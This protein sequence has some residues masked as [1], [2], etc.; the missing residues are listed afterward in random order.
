MADEHTSSG[1]ARR[2]LLLAAVGATGAGL[3][4]LGPA[5][6]A[7]AATGAMDYGASNDAGSSPTSL[8]STA[9]Q[10][11]AVDNSA[12]GV[13]LAATA[14]GH[15]AVQ[16]ATSADTKSGVYAVDR[17]KNGGYGVYATSSSGVGVHGASGSGAGVQG[18][19]DSGIGVYAEG[20][21][22][23]VYAKSSDGSAFFAEGTD[24][25]NAFI[26]NAI[27]GAGVVANTVTG[28]G[29]QVESESGTGATIQS[30]GDVGLEVIT[31]G[32]VSYGVRI[33]DAEPTG[34]RCL[35]V[36]SQGPL[37]VEVENTNPDGIGINV[38]APSTGIRAFGG[39][40]ALW[41]EGPTFFSQSGRAVI[42]AGR[43]SL[44][45]SGI[46]DGTPLG[47][48]VLIVATLQAYRRGT[49]VE[50]AYVEETATGA[51]QV[52]IR[53]NT[54]VLRDTPVAWFAF[55]GDHG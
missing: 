16:A 52:T 33:R 27:H 48:D 45:F 15:D 28:I 31:T 32:P 43:S 49:H 40:F 23:G 37:A 14:T 12:S 5:Q 7:D 54:L 11:L 1:I 41:V 8:S 47:A 44:T 42:P 35:D 2:G 30:G 17:S 39:R 26:G 29:L 55:A 50:A 13:A 20:A 19:S 24:H 25:G 36:H 46:F 22:A 34:N 4:A 6:L 38:T 21:Y 3:A 10:T 9:D 51:T 53:L 18:T